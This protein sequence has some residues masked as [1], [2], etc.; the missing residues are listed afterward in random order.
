MNPIN[1]FTL[2]IIFIHIKF[3]PLICSCFIGASSFWNFRNKIMNEAIISTWSSCMPGPSYYKLLV[4][5]T[6][7][8]ICEET[9]KLLETSQCVLSTHF[10]IYFLL[11]PNIFLINFVLILS[12]PFS[13]PV[14]KK[15]GLEFRIF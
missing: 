11:G 7:A 10:R 5:I 3:H 15:L 2:S 9:L 1:I 12:G 4:L 8:Q 14:N 6:L 13:Y